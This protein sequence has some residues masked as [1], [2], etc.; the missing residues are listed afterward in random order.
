MFGKTAFVPTLPR[1]AG[2]DMSFVKV[3]E[4][5]IE[6]ISQWIAAGVRVSKGA[7]T[8]RYTDKSL[9]VLTAII[10]HLDRS[11]NM[12]RVSYATLMHTA[13]I[14]RGTLADHLYLLETHAQYIE[15][16]RGRVSQSKSK[17]NVFRLVGVVAACVLARHSVQPLN[18]NQNLWM[19]GWESYPEHIKAFGIEKPVLVRLVSEYGLARVEACIEWAGRQTWASNPVGLAVSKIRDGGFEPNDEKAEA[20]ADETGQSVIVADEWDE[21]AFRR[22]EARLER[23]RL[24]SEKLASLRV[25]DAGWRMAYTQLKLQMDSQTFGAW[26]S[27][28]VLVG[29]EGKIYTML[30]KNAATRDMCQ[31]RLYR[32][33]QRLLADTTG[34]PDVEIVFTVAEVAA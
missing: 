26:L 12:A 23:E 6:Q 27:E 13:G 24:A 25:D 19:D 32:N 28:L 10:K 14:A 9:V 22:W 1:F 11:R 21:E 18:T 7:R 33:I 16:Q 5:A 29:V 4:L 15:I 2:K 31:H 3:P 20:E 8:L 30:A 34:N 17:I